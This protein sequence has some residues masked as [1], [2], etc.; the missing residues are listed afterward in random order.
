MPSQVL[1]PKRPGGEIGRHVRFRC[2]CFAACGFESRLGHKAQEKGLVQASKIE[3]F[4]RFFY[5]ESIDLLC[6]YENTHNYICMNK[7]F[8]TELWYFLL[9]IMGGVLIIVLLSL[10]PFVF[11]DTLTSSDTLFFHVVQWLQTIFV[12]TL[13]ALLWSRWRMKKPCS[14]TL[15]TG[16][17]ASWKPYAIVILLSL[18]SLP[19]FD[20]L[21]EACRQIPL[22]V[23]IRQ[24]AENETA[25]QEALLEK[26]L[27]VHGCAG[28]LEL[29][30]LMSIG[31]AIGEE[32]TF[33]GALLTI[34]RRY[35]KFNK[36]LIAILVGF[37]FSAIHMEIYGL[38]PR[39]ILG[40]IFVYIVYY[41]GS[42][43]PAVLAHALNNLYALLEYKGIFG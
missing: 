4:W 28:W 35:T 12:M 38:I 6:V 36:H 25:T 40:T 5:S 43:W 2:V 17:E 30:L 24:Y 1:V 7:K 32:L 14:V 26:M 11:D 15:M 10:M 31:T 8:W 23:A 13:P 37:I 19:L 34:F 39:W 33:R 22:P 9:F 18:I 29:I 41:S 42:I 16:F 27:D 3:R 20:W 21:G